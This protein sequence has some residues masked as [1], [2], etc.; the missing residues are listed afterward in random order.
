[1]S[2]AWRCV[3]LNVSYRVRLR[4]AWTYVVGGVYPLVFAGRELLLCGTEMD[5]VPCEDVVDGWWDTVEDVGAVVPVVMV[6]DRGDSGIS[7]MESSWT[8]TK[9]LICTGQNGGLVFKKSITCACARSQLTKY[10]FSSS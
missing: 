4:A 7:I 2:R 1:M 8:G 3:C 5:T 6:S 9:A 10:K